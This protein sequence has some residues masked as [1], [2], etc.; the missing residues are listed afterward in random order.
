MGLKP[1]LQVRSAHPL[2]SP[3]CVLYAI[4]CLCRHVTKDTE[5]LGRMFLWALGRAEFGGRRRRRLSFV[6]LC[7]VITSNII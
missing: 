6:F 5:Q 4:L 7:L 1:R 2:C 3:L